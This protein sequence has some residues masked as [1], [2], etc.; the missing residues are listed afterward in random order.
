MH[1]E[2]LKKIFKI[3]IPAMVILISYSMEEVIFKAVFNRHLPEKLMIAASGLSHMYPQ[4][5]A[6]L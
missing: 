3:L 5:Y 2:K 4:S 1:L 6:S